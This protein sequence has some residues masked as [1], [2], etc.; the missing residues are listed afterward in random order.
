MTANEFNEKYKEWLPEG[1]YGLGFDIPP[2]TEFLDDVF[3]DLT[4]IPGF[5]YHQI[6]L[7]FNMPRF[8]TN[9]EHGLSHTIETRIGSLV[10]AWDEQ[11]KAAKEKRI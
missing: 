4:K 11:L 7:K 8:Y 9:L 10:K 2:V 5:E 1:W 3:K 6:K